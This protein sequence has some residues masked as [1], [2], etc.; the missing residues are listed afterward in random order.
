MMCHPERSLCVL[1]VKRSRRICGSPVVLQNC[2]EPKK[3]SPLSRYNLVVDRHSPLATTVSETGYLCLRDTL[4][5]STGSC[6]SS[7][8][9][10]SAKSLPTPSSAELSSPSSS[11]CA[12]SGRSLSS[13]SAPLHLQQTL[14]ASL[15]TPFPTRSPS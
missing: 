11:S 13:S 15:P 14:P 7:P 2:R 5:V 12:T 1:C 6:A 4:K 9:T 8:V 10:S 3:S